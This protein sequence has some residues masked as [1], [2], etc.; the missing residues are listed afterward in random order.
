LSAGRNRL[1][2]DLRAAYRLERSPAFGFAAACSLVPY[3]RD[4]GVSHLHVSPGQPESE[5]TE[6][7]RLAAA[8]RD[9]GMG[10][11]IDV[12]QGHELADEGI[13]DGLC[14]R[15]LDGLA[16][17]AAYLASVRGRG[18]DRVWVD[19][20]L[21][22]TE[23]LRDWPICGTLGENFLNDVCA[24][25]VDP[26]GEERLTAL[27]QKVSGDRS[28]FHEVAF[29]AKLEQ[30]HET[31]WPQLERLSRD[32]G[33]AIP[34]GLEA[35]ARALASLP[36]YR[37]YVAPVERRVEEDDRRAIAAAHMQPA[38]A[39]M[40]LLERPALAEFI[41][42][43]QQTTPAVMAKGLEGT[44]FYRYGRLLALNEVGGDPGRFGIDV[45]RFH[46]GCLERAERFP[47]TLLS[48][49]TR[50]SRRSPDVRGRIGALASVAEEWETAVE[51]W[52]ELTEPMREEGAPDDVERY[53]LFQ[54]LVGT[55]PIE[56]ERIESYM[57]TVLRAARRHTSAA[58]PN[59]EWEGAVARFCRALYEDD[60]FV[61][62]LDHFVPWVAAVGE[63][64]ALGQVVL[65]LT[66]PGIPSLYQGDE[67]PYRVLA[68]DRPPVDWQWHQSMLR[69][70]MGGSPP[71]AQNRKLF[72]ILRLL[73][74]RAR[75]PIA[76]L[77]SY[78]PLSA[79]AGACA[80]MRGGEV[81]VVVAVRGGGE[82][83]MLEAPR[84]RWR[85]VLRGEERSFGTREPLTNLLGSHGLAVFERIDG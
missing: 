18:I 5:E 36:V 48:T 58:E 46:H 51:R 11:L 69:R 47:R 15:Q 78:E 72:V 9:A 57:Q 81:L 75:R 53:F 13:A 29:E 50:D 54:T 8:A 2:V 23:R 62:E 1:A 79:G 65:K 59:L 42:R 32:L 17:P 25:F 34:G 63:R 74:L 39:E 19:K 82:Q 28:D 55:W 61:A 56:R 83:A 70:L 3:L 73:G 35:L 24:L 80:F 37:T 27:W 14:V 30:V 41:T 20:V 6:L 21:Q 40:L 76:F 10:L 22:P 49:Q 44:A 45:E 85:D 66:S 43:F 31:L 33:G 52:L 64:A 68:E 16:D 26:A 71:V 60:Q 12:E 67:L 84:G 4:L 7:R 38:L 77:S